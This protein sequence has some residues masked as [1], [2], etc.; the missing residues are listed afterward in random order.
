MPF[1]DLICVF[2]KL[3]FRSPLHHAFRKRQNKLFCFRG[4]NFSDSYLLS[5]G[6]SC[7]LPDEVI[8]SHES[9]VPVLPV[10]SPYFCSGL[11]LPP[12]FHNIA[13]RELKFQQSCR[14]KS[15]NSSSK[16][17]RICLFNL[18]LYFFHRS[19]RK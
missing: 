10:S 2:P 4:F 12:Y 3:K 19:S 6:N 5:Y 17:N 11:F 16:V 15:D 14:I 9:L 18:Q 8:N 7:I 1:Y 13:W